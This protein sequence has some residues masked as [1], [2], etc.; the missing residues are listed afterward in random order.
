VISLS[1]RYAC[2][3]AEGEPEHLLAAL[4]QV[5]DGAAAPRQMEPA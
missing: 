4:G 5:L 1:V 3:E 2:G